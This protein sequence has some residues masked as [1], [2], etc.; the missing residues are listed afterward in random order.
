MAGFLQEFLF[1][2]A[3]EKIA[4]LGVK[5]DDMVITQSQ[6]IGITQQFIDPYGSFAYD[7]IYNLNLQDI[8]S[9]KT[10]AFFDNDYVSRRESLRKFSLNGEIDFILDTICDE[11]IVYDDYN[12]FCQLNIDKLANYITNEKELNEI[13]EYLQIEFNKIYNLL[14]FS[15]WHEAWFYMKKF[16]IDGFLAFEI[17]Y[18]EEYNSIIGFKELDPATLRPDIQKSQDGTYSRVYVQ[19]VRNQGVSTNTQRILYDSQVIYISYSRANFISRF[20]YV[21]NLV[22]SFNLLRI[23]ENSRIIWNFI[24]SQYRLKIEVPVNSRSP[25]K[26]RESLAEYTN[27]LREDISI[28]NESGELIING[29]PNLKFFKNYIIPKREGEGINIE[30][31]EN[32]GMELRDTD[33]LEYFLK[34]LMIDSKLPFSRF[35][36]WKGESSASYPDSLSSIEREE[37]SFFNFINRIRS[38]FQEIILKPL[39]LSLLLKYPEFEN[40]FNIKSSIGLR[41]N[42]N[43]LFKEMKQ[44]KIWADAQQVISSFMEIKIKGWDEVNGEISDEINYFDID[45]LL[46]KFLHLSDEDIEMNNKLKEQKIKELLEKKKKSGDSEKKEE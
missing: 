33:I 36:H 3:R 25:Q 27:M 38:A 17:I 9:K 18:D 31:L 20:S 7:M 6:G 11:A 10:I 22:R 4:K 23:A 2:D 40:D 15:E 14:N 44:Q 39:W 37:I 5:Y 32:R 34:K 42:D 24:N 30:T 26:A 35:G 13:K 46:K 29:K 19:E 8:E 45:F 28:N 41:F 43:N 1:G 21:E 16:L 12:Y